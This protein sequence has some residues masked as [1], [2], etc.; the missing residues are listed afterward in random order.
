MNL[1]REDVDRIVKNMLKDEVE[2]IV[3]ETVKKSL[4]VEIYEDCGTVS[5][6]LQWNGNRF[7]KDT[8]TVNERDY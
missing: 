4:S 7:S 5:V 1:T 8:A 6:T 3:E 2:K